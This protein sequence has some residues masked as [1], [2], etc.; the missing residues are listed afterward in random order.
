MK[1]CP[2]CG[3]TKSL[4]EFHKHK[5]NKLGV[6]V[7]CKLCTKEND[8]IRWKKT[9]SSG[10]LIKY[11]IAKKNYLKHGMKYKEQAHIRKYGKTI[12]QRQSILDK[13]NGKCAIC[14]DK[15]SGRLRHGVKSPFAIAGE[16]DHNHATGKVRGLL[17]QPCNTALGLLKEDIKIIESMREYIT[18]Y[19]K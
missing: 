15:L 9:D 12:G 19:G 17:C 3:F 7:Y 16:L 18:A 5:L 6:Q 8:A 4:S 2:K 11:A 14:L 1:K 13:Q 10:R